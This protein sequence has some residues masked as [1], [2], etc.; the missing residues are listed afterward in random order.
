MGHGL[1]GLA[2]VKVRPLTFDTL[3]A[4]IAS[5]GIEPDEQV[6]VT[7][8]GEKLIAGDFSRLQSTADGIVIVRKP[9]IVAV[10][11]FVPCDESGTRTSVRSV[12][13]RSR[14]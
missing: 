13:P 12:S 1:G 7:T 9:A 10:A 11:G 8:I 2:P 4:E 6:K 14:W 3:V 5:R